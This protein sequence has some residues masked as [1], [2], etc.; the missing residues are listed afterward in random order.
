MA[1]PLQ[2]IRLSLKEHKQEKIISTAPCNWSRNSFFPGVVERGSARKC[3]VT[4][5]VVPKNDLPIRVS[6]S[7]RMKAKEGDEERVALTKEPKR[8]LADAW[9]EIQGQNDWAGMLDPLDPL[10]RAELIRYGDMAQ[11]C[12]DAYEFDPYS[13]YCGSCKVKPSMFFENLGWK[14]CSYE[15]TSYIYSTYNVNFP[16]F[17]NV[18]L[19]PDGWSHSANWIGYVAVSNEEYS[20]YLGRRDIM[21]AWRGT[22]TNAEKIADLMD[23]QNPTTY[24]TIP[25]RDPTIKVEAGFLDLYAGRNV[26]CQYCK[27]SAREQV[28]AE[29]KRLKELYPGEELSITITGHSLGSALATLNAYDIAEIGLDVMEDGRV[30]PVTVF[31]FSGPRVGNARFKERLE[32]LGVKILRIFNVHD[33]V[34]KVPGIFLNELVPKVLQQLG[35]W[36][37]WCYFHVGE[38]LPLNHENSPFLKDESNLVFFHNLEVLLHLLDGYHGKGRRFWLAGGRD[39]ALVNKTT[40]FLKKDFLIPPNWWETNNRMFFKNHLGQWVMPEQHDLEIHTPSEDVQHHL[41]QL[42]LAC[43]AQWH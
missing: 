27:Y 18:S 2:R 23:F 22:V 11:A 39:I 42:N 38:E 9:R 43:H 12:Y 10:L 4:T 29:V 16:K 36:L 32:G 30:I 25:S 14:K 7:E 24:H 37:P 1:I 19:N 21:I 34:P 13:K 26:D 20:K 31:S 40:D 17:F 28:L 8:K 5:K 6:D 35:G 15:V 41:Q 33:Q 3:L